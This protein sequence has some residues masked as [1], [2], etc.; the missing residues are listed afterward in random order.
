MHCSF[1]R[2]RDLLC[3]RLLK[4]NS[5]NFFGQGERWHRTVV[6][7]RAA[8]PSCPGF[9]SWRFQFF[10]GQRKIVNFAK[11]NR[12]RRCIEQRTVE[13]K[14]HQLNPFSTGKLE[15][16]KR[17]NFFLDWKLKI[18]GHFILFFSFDFSFVAFFE[19]P[20]PF[21]NRWKYSFK[22]LP[23][24]LSFSAAVRLSPPPTFACWLSWCDIKIESWM[25]FWM[26]FNGYTM[27]ECRIISCSRQIPACLTINTVL[28][29]VLNVFQPN[30]KSA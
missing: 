23:R 29:F 12:Q 5:N 21:I 4:S 30:N 20:P 7:I 1:L 17:K 25:Q 15:I 10:S 22:M 18:G 2:A 26:F 27:H 8:G 9:D 3:H 6:S 11:V 24:A 16:Q 28:H 13:A 19:S 14:L